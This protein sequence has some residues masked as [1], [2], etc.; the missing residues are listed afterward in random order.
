MTHDPVSA[1]LQRF[2]WE[3]AEHEAR[4]LAAAQVIAD[5]PHIAEMIT[6]VICEYAA[7][8]MARPV[9]FG[10]TPIN[11]ILDLIHKELSDGKTLHLR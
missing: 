9:G 6:D 8:P 10:A 11:Q 4:K 5:N 7:D 1:S 3:E 2:E